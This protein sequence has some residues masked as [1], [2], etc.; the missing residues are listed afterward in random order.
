M[1]W[2]LLLPYDFC[3]ILSRSNTMM[4]LK[5]YTLPELGYD[6]AA[7]EPIYSREMLELH[8]DKHHAAYVKGANRAVEN[9][10][11]ARDTSDYGII[12]QLQKDLAFNLSGHILHSLFWRNM[13]PKGGGEPKGLL[14]SVIKG[15]FGGDG[16][17]REQLSRA[18]TSIQ[19]SGWA[20]LCYE[21]LGRKLIVEQI[22]DHQGNLGNAAVPLLVLD[23][24]E[25]AYYLQYKNDK[26]RWV[27]RF[28]DLVDWQDVGARFESVSPLDLR[29]AAA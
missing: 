3:R 17:L 28:W 27:K 4:D 18:A 14:A 8:H 24:W 29:L 10:A 16:A 19:G 20:A 26:Q 11:E 2:K 13:S 9:L 6:Y 15:S 7:L 22:Y 23:M 25:H 5:A 1:A 12:N 21:P